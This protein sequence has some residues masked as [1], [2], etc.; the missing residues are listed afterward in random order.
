MNGDCQGIKVRAWDGKRIRKVFKI[1]FSDE[2]FVHFTE[3]KPNE[4][5]HLTL[6]DE[7][8]RLMQFN[9]LKDKNGVNRCDGDIIRRST[10]YIFVEEKKWFSL[11]G[12]NDAKAY[13]YDYHP[14]DEIIGNVY[15]NP[16]LLN[17]E[18]GDKT[19]VATDAE[20]R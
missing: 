13:G 5:G 16:E 8:V 6:T 15:E 9:G 14:N 10:G 1:V 17:S 3:T 12:K 2:T 4:P 20:Q 11:G 19:S 18:Q 7:R